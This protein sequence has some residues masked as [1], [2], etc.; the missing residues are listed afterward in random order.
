M[1]R[2]ALVGEPD[3]SLRRQVVVTLQHAGYTVRESAG[4]GELRVRLRSTAAYVVQPLIVVIGAAFAE[5][6]SEVISK[7][8]RARSVAGLSRPLLVLLCATEPVRL[9]LPA[10]DG[11]DLAVAMLEN[12]EAQGTMHW[13]ESRPLL[14]QMAGMRLVESQQ[15]G[16]LHPIS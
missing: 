16:S 15:A 7:L 6:C 2:L 5:S 9:S 11:C 12:L 3:V 13:V 1:D 10:L 14:L 4:I 8:G